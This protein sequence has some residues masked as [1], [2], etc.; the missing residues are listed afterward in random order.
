MFCKNCGAQLTDGAA[1]CPTC[2]VSVEVTEQINPATIAAAPKPELPMGWFKFIVNFS[3]FAAA[4]LNLI[5]FVTYISGQH[6]DG[7]ADLVYA[8]FPNLK[9][10]DI[11]MAFVAIILAVYAIITRFQ[12]AKFRKIGP[13]MLYILPVVN[14]LVQVI[15]AVGVI[16]ITSSLIPA[17]EAINFAS[18]GSNIAGSIAIEVINIIYFSKR[19]H[20]FVN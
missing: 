3:L 8:I 17:N 4:A 12:L 14:I 6:Y 19:K 11:S 18:L 16:S 10:L 1:F 2:G 9:T 7:E 5:N 20:L 15:S 13:M